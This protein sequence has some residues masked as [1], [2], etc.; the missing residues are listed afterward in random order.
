[1]N[2]SKKQSVLKIGQVSYALEDHRER[3]VYREKRITL[4]I[5]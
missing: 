3:H 5:P 1:M 2:S 4:C